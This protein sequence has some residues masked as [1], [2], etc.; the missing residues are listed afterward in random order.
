MR[1]IK[2][3]KREGYSYDYPDW[4]KSLVARGKVVPSQAKLRLWVDVPAGGQVDCYNGDS[5]V[6]ISEGNKE[7]TLV[8]RGD[9]PVD[10]EWFETVSLKS[11]ASDSVLKAIDTV[12]KFLKDGLQTEVFD[13]FGRYKA[14]DMVVDL[15]ELKKWLNS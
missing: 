13:Q 12:G 3:W 8:I 6:W 10:N 15:G 4:V 14:K 7:L 1:Q 2:I 11:I 5:I 9:R